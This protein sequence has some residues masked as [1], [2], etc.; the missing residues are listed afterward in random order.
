MSSS[1][2]ASGVRITPADATGALPAGVTVPGNRTPLA[3]RDDDIKIV[4]GR[5]IQICFIRRIPVAYL[6]GSAPRK[7]F[8][9]F[10]FVGGGR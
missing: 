9:I 2:G 6:P 5:K 4:L 7:L 3:P 8:V 10:P 1:R